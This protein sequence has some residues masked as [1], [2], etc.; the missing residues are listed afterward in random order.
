M[1]GLRV[2]D[3][4]RVR[5]EILRELLY[6][7]NSK[8]FDE[9]SEKV[10][11]EVAFFDSC[12]EEVKAE[13]EDCSS[14]NEVC[15]HIKINNIGFSYSIEDMEENNVKDEKEK[16]FPVDY[17]YL[18]VDKEDLGNIIDKLNAVYTVMDRKESGKKKSIK[19][20]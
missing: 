2:K 11:D 12:D 17:P 18:I 13:I 19:V 6:L 15:L 4:S 16:H 10:R 8:N 20:P 9:F 3:M 14:T 5:E 1:K 7:V